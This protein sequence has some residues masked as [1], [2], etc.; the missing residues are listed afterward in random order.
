MQLFAYDQN[1]RLVMANRAERGQAYYCLDCRSE[2]RLRG[3]PLRQRHFFHLQ[4]TRPCRLSGKTL[5]HLQVQYFLQDQLPDGEV[6]LEAP[7]PG[8]R[9]IADVYWKNKKIIFEVQCSPISSEE[10]LNRNRDYA[11]LGFHVVWI[12]HDKRYNQRFLSSA[13]R[14]LQE[15]PHYYTNIDATGEGIIY[16]QYARILESRRLRKLPPLAI[17]VDSPLLAFPQPN[18]LQLVKERACTWPLCFEGDLAT[19]GDEPSD[20]Q[21]LAQALS[22][23]PDYTKP[24][25]VRYEEFK[26][27]FKKGLELFIFR[28]YR[29]LFRYI[30]EGYTKHN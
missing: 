13:E 1:Q 17:S 16:D 2:L 26:R 12:L 23:E 11:S 22:I 28:P 18:S 20:V 8:I 10:V 6:V 21:Y 9:R 19:L 27:L 29:I 5:E 7:F 24:T 14:S 3:G 30:L 15:H 25:S 4:H